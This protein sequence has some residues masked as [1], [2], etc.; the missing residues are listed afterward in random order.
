MYVAMYYFQ[1]GQSQEGCSREGS[2]GRGKTKTFP[3]T[4]VSLK[5]D[6]IYIYMR[7]EGR[8]RPTARM[9]YIESVKYAFQ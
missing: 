1:G 8:A 2:E 6:E 7:K 9:Q 5:K 4:G 3:T